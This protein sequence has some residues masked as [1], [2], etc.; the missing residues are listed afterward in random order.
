METLTGSGKSRLNHYSQASNFDVNLFN[1]LHTRNTNCLGVL[2]ENK[3]LV[4]QR[5]NFDHK[6]VGLKAVEMLVALQL[7]YG[8][9]RET[10]SNI[11][12]S[13]LKI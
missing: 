7:L 6:F 13:T 1:P 12:L 10:P 3:I 2:V 5:V 9:L 11:F 4:V 8:G